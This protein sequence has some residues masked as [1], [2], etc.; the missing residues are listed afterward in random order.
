MH[1]VTFN[2][3]DLPLHGKG[4]WLI[5]LLLATGL[6]GGGGDYKSHN[7]LY[8]QSGI[9]KEFFAGVGRQAC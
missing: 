4:E 8:D 6:G 1:H 9:D 7:N 5:T 3:V 2:K